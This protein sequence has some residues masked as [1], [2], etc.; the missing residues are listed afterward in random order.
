LLTKNK[1]V[2]CQTI[3]KT[4]A[5]REINTGACKTTKAKVGL[6]VPVNHHL[7]PGIQFPDMVLLLLQVIRE[8]KE[9][10]NN[11]DL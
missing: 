8:T 5:A 7:V 1:E 9:V 3:K 11:E 6:K 10:I 4:K 2:K